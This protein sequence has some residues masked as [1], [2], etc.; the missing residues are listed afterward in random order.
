MTSLTP[1]PISTNTADKPQSKVW[2]HA[3]K[4]WTVL[5]NAEG[6]FLWR[7]D[8]TSWT[9]MLT[10]SNSSFG[11]ADCKVV[12]NV[13]HVLVYRGDNDS[14]LY[15]LEYD[16]ATSTYKPWSLQTAR[17]SFTLGPESETATLDIDGSG[18]MWIAY[19][20]PR[21]VRVR[22]SDSPYSTWSD[23]IVIASGIADDDITGLIALPNKIAVLW[24]NQRTE[25]FGMKTHQDGASPSTWSADEMPASQSSQMVGAGFADDHLNMAVAKDGTLFCAV[26]TGY[27][28]PGYAKLALLVRRPNGTWDNAYKVTETEGT[29]PIVI[30]NEAIGKI[31]V[32]YTAQENGGD[33]LY[34]ES[35]LTSISFGAPITLLRGNHNYISSTKAN[36]TRETVIIATEVNGTDWKAVGVLVTD[37]PAVVTGLLDEDA[38]KDRHFYELTAYPNPFSQ[39]TTLRFSLKETSDY[40]VDLYD[41]KGSGL[42]QF[43][44]GRAMKGAEIKIDITGAG[45][46]PGVYLIKITTQNGSKTIRLVHTQK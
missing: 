27:E 16:A 12:D 14:H 11:R 24:S 15:S 18:R 22:W 17:S 26:K 36:H 4:F 23:P 21:E 20:T 13:V 39:M 10:I 45:L 40:T 34:K 35:S 28:T 25:M 37:P 7:L 43:G 8:G 46:S 6:T 44:Q 29:R 32:V 5:P 3:G 19:D 42:G 30:L 9:K 41:H 31:R 33:V 2:M 1:M 38:G